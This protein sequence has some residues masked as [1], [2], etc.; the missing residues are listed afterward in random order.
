MFDPDGRIQG[1]TLDWSYRRA[2]LN[3]ILTGNRHFV[4]AVATCNETFFEGRKLAA[5]THLKEE[6]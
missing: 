3:L 4:V 5:T 2:L 1:K 6:P